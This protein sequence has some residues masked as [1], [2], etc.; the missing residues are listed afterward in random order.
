MG[1]REQRERLDEW[2]DEGAAIKWFKLFEEEIKDEIRI[3]RLFNNFLEEVRAGG[4]S[5]LK[6]PPFPFGISFSHESLLPQPQSQCQRAE[7]WELNALRYSISLITLPRP[8]GHPI[9]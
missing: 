7:H 6:F 3:A 9:V 1:G 8:M 2:L 4:G 5:S